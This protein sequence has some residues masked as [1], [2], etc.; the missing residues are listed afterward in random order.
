M[1]Y[2][3][4]SSTGGFA[5]FSEIWYRGN[6][7]WKIYVDGKPTKMIRTDYL[8]RGAFIPSGSH[9][10]EMRYTQEKLDFLRTLGQLASLLL[11]IVVITIPYIEGRLRKRITTISP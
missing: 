9:K 7:D 8:L 5:V 4:S 2:S 3:S 10:I 11:I 1:E 6:E